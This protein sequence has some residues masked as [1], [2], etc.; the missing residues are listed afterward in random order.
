MTVHADTKENAIKVLVTEAGL[1]YSGEIWGIP[2]PGDI[3][4]VWL[5][6]LEGETIGR[7]SD[8][9]S[10][11][12]YINDQTF[13]EME[14]YYAVEKYGTVELKQRYAGNSFEL[15]VLEPY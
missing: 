8:W 15:P 3:P 6:I 7:Q 9:R 10:F 4:G 2:D 5:I 12:V 11:I 13:E 14:T 1:Q